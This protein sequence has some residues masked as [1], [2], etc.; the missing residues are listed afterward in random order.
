M[1]FMKFRL[2]IDFEVS[3][4][5]YYDASPHEIEKTERWLLVAKGIKD[6]LELVAKYIIVGRQTMPHEIRLDLI[7]LPKEKQ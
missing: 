7:E 3:D 2:T 6:Y 4:D 1:K 5:A